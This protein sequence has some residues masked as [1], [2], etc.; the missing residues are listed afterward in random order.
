MLLPVAVVSAC[1]R[2][3]SEMN[4]DGRIQLTPDWMN[5]IKLVLF[6]RIW[7]CVYAWIRDP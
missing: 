1:A 3:W 7:A 4:P 5:C 6:V 2:E